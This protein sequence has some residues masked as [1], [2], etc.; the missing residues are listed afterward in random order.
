VGTVFGLPLHPLVVHGTVVVVPVAAL[1]VIVV[2][3]WRRVRS[4]LAWPAFVA[5][6]AASGLVALAALSG[7]PLAREVPPSAL[8]AHH[9]QLAK[10]LVV[11]VVAMTGASFALACLA[12]WRVGAPVPDRL[13]V[14][15]RLAALARPAWAARLVAVRWIVPV[16][17]GLSVL[18]GVGTLVQV[19]LVGHSGAQATWSTGVPVRPSKADGGHR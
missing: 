11:W 19:V 9:A 15:P 18:T 1:L 16:A 7:K 4:R 3:L 6:V 14:P 10:L 17:V 2:G 13:R 8:V 5:S 12:W